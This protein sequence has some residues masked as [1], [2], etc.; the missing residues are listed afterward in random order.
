MR[1]Y[2]HFALIACV[3]SLPACARPAQEAVP[4]AAATS[5]AAKSWLADVTAIADADA[6]P[7]RR[8]AIAKR[9]DTLG[10]QW[11]NSAFEVD[12]EKGTNILADVGGNASAPLL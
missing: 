12:G 5:P 3:L 4:P 7:G 2:L 6:G 1:P 8:T 11:R 10:I 9:L